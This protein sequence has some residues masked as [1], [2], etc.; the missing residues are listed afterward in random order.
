VKTI[1]TILILPVA[2]LAVF[3]QA[4]LAGVRDIIGAQV[5]LLPALIVYAALQGGLRAV[6]L[7]SVCGGLWFDSLSANTLGVSVLPL[8]AVGFLIYQQRELIL[9]SQRFAQFVLGLTASLVVPL[10]TLL[11]MFTMGETPLVGWGTLWQLLVMGLLGG[12]LTPVCFRFFSF[13]RRTFFYS[14][15]TQ[16]TFRSDRE[17]RRGRT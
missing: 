3:L 2:F 16:T 12:A 17:I 5:N 15:A 7:L 13:V 6:A 4:A 14:P 10:L 1:N 8:F 9:R 11:L